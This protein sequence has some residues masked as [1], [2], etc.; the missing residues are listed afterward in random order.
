MLIGYDLKDKENLN[1][2]Q[3]TRDFSIKTLGNYAINKWKCYNI[4]NH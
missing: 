3:K 4:S 2:Q 1:M